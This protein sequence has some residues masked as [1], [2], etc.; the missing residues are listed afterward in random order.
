[1]KNSLFSQTDTEQCKAWGVLPLIWED[2]WE[3][4][5]VAAHPE[6]WQISL[7][8]PLWR[9]TIA[10][11]I[12]LRKRNEF[13][14]KNTEICSSRRTTRVLRWLQDGQELQYMHKENKKRWIRS[15]AGAAQSTN[16]SWARAQWWHSYISFRYSPRASGPSQGQIKAY[17][18]SPAALD[19]CEMEYCDWFIFGKGHVYL[20]EDGIGLLPLGGGDIKLLG[21]RWF[22]RV[23]SHVPDVGAQQRPVL[24]LLLQS[25]NI[26]STPPRSSKISLSLCWIYTKSQRRECAIITQFSEQLVADKQYGKALL[27]SI[28]CFL[29]CLFLKRWLRAFLAPRPCV[30]GTWLSC[31]LQSR[32]C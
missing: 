9:G 25:F 22:S 8:L 17:L 31:L 10:S 32:T 19:R 16:L 14:R 3:C 24:V 23:P 29:S 18:S 4:S 1:M 20:G 30:C 21:K 6:L 5:A 13:C 7:C 26:L 15:T 11:C 12:S 27:V 2:I 28:T